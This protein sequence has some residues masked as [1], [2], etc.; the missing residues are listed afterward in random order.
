MIIKI[1][2]YGAGF[3]NNDVAVLV[4]ADDL[5]YYIYVRDMQP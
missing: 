1:R 2:H 5:H 3:H 4:L